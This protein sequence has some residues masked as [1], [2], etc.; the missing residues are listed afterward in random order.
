MCVLTQ[1]CKPAIDLSAVRKL[2]APRKSEESRNIRIHDREAGLVEV[3][4][5][6]TKGTFYFVGRLDEEGISFRWNKWNKVE[7]RVV[8]THD[9]CLGNGT[10]EFPPTCDCRG[11]LG[12]GQCKHAAG[13][14]A[15]LEAGKI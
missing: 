2:L 13:T 3:I 4:E 10:K 8:E 6:G 1:T 7:S 5:G 9:C 12:H 15:L 14:I 11:F